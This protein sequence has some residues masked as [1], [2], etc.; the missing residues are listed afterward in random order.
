[1]KLL[2]TREGLVVLDGSPGPLEIIAVDDSGHVKRLYLPKDPVESIV[3]KLLNNK[4]DLS[5]HEKTH[6]A[7]SPKS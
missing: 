4:N 5:K 2:I 6:C 7:K 1:M 3:R